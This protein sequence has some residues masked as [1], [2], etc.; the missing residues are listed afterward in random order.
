MTN[1]KADVDSSIH[2]LSNSI[3]TLQYFIDD[4]AS[5]AV[6]LTT[7][8]GKECVAMARRALSNVE[9]ALQVLRDV[10]SQIP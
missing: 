5:A 7:D 2:G 6:D 3:I 9:A 10:R 8:E 4:V 1:S